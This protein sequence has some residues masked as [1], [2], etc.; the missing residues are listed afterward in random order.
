MSFHKLST[1][2]TTQLMNSLHGVA[3]V[4]GVLGFMVGLS[5]LIATALLVWS[6]VGQIDLTPLA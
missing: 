1:L 4:T 6:W 2:L 5:A 3:I